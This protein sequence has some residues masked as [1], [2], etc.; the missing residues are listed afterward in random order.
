MYN[1]LLFGSHLLERPGHYEE[2]EAF[3]EEKKA[4]LPLGGDDGDIVDSAFRNDVLQNMKVGL[5]VNNCRAP[6][7]NMITGAHKHRHI[8][9]AS[10]NLHWLV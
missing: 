9:M 8:A 6:C 10:V 5:V 1:F 2:L 4:T 7:I 3:W